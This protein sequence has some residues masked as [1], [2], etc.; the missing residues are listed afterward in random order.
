MAKLLINSMD[1]AFEPELYHDE[2]QERL[3]GVIEQ[4]I[5]GK[6]IVA[7]APEEKTNVID[8]M[9]ALKAS[10]E[11]QKVKPTPKRKRASGA[12]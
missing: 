3:C 12:R 2:Y 8:L 5:A 6:E 4:K 1:K 11:Q 9:E 7:A 10:L